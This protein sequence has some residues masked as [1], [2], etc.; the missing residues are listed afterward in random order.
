M[1]NERRKKKQTTNY[2][3][4]HKLLVRIM[5]CGVGDAVTRDYGNN[6]KRVIEGETTVTRG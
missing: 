1:S 6:Y 5:W 3:C 4:S 2:G